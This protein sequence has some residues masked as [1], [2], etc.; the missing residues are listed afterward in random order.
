MIQ[1]VTFIIIR[2]W[3]PVCFLPSSSFLWN[4]YV[5][6][7]RNQFR[8]HSWHLSTAALS[9]T[10]WNLT[11]EHRLIWLSLKDA[12]KS[13]H[14]A[15]L[16]MFVCLHLC[17]KWLGLEGFHKC[18][19]LQCSPEACGRLETRCW[20]PAQLDVPNSFI[21]RCKV[22]IT[23]D[24]PLI[25]LSTPCSILPLPMNKRWGTWT[26]LLGEGTPPFFQLRTIASDLEE[27]VLIL[28]YCELI[29]QELVVTDSNRTTSTAKSRDQIL[30]RALAIRWGEA[31]YI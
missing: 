10:L 14:C 17:G 30:T 29:Q 22:R 6:C 3:A 12:A 9:V 25:R 5:C 20:F 19:L 24:T 13:P 7:W 18:L 16:L 21:H 15:A 11:M 1:S 23:A 4:E 2:L 28:A 26:P 8:N 27:L 31:D